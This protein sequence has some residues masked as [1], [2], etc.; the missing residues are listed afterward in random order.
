MDGS[1]GLVA[2]GPSLLAV[3]V[4]NKLD[5]IFI[6][7]LKSLMVLPIRLC[8]WC[9]WES[10]AATNRWARRRGRRW[11]VVLWDQNHIL[12]AT[13]ISCYMAKIASTF[14]KH[15]TRFVAHSLNALPS[16]WPSSS[17]P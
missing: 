12:L 15:T 6:A 5:V 1:V 13:R 16:R 14:L 8:S 10:L 11:F 2:L 7:E 4:I 17:S 3:I 9:F